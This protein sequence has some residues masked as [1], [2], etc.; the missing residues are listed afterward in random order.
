MFAGHLKTLSRGGSKDSSGI[1][2]IKVISQG[3]VCL[4]LLY[5]QR[6]DYRRFL[7][8]NLL[9]QSNIVIYSMYL[10]LW[11]YMIK[12][13]GAKSLMSFRDHIF[14]MTAPARLIC[15]P[16]PAR[17]F[18]RVLHVTELIPLLTNRHLSGDKLSEFIK[19]TVLP[20]HSVE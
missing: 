1:S 2:V 10:T 8:S 3:Q 4:L 13:K 9:L 6:S 12:M 20:G 18:H 17:K 15:T 16:T 5:A 11:P 7:P 19:V 14:V